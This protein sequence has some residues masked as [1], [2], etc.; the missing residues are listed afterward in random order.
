MAVQNRNK[1][2]AYVVGKGLFEKLERMVE[3]FIDRKAIEETDFS[4]GENL[5]KV[6][7]KLGI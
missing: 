5:E 7:K 6:M 2:E 4:K 1:T 3:D